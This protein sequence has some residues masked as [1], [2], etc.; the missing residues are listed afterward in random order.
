MPPVVPW[1]VSI[2]DRKTGVGW[3]PSGQSSLSVEGEGIRLPVAPD[4]LPLGRRRGKEGLGRRLERSSS[5][6]RKDVSFESPDRLFE[7]GVQTGNLV[8]EVS[9]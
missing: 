8:P 4:L 5:P 3:G 1:C 7:T 9:V 2:L 6:V